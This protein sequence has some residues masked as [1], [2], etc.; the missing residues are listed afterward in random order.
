MN[1]ARTAERLHVHVN[2]ARYY[3]LSR[4]AERTGRQPAQRP[5]T[6]LD[7][8]LAIKMLSGTR[9]DGRRPPG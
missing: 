9:H 5:P 7:L 8:L 4:I 2:T 3:R 6:M 1:I